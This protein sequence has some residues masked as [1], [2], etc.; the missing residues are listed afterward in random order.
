ML[1]YD[2]QSG[3]FSK[4]EERLKTK[5]GYSVGEKGNMDADEYN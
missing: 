1:P 5:E 2:L 3:F 4:V